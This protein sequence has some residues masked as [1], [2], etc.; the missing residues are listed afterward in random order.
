M[1]AKKS[2]SHHTQARARKVTSGGTAVRERVRDLSVRAFRERNL[3]LNEVPRIVNDVLEG[4]VEGIDKSIPS[5]GRNVLRDVFDG[6]REGVTAVASAGSA[7]VRDGRARVRTMTDKGL[8]D[9]ARRVR[10][11][12][13]EFLGAVRDFASK[14]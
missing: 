13:D 1:A 6:L 5:S 3:S 8:P 4:A 7:S 14:T 12:N 9:A 11:A 2:S 10:A